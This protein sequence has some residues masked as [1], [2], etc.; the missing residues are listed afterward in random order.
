MKNLKEFNL[1]RLK[2]IF[3]NR[4]DIFINILLIG[5]TLFATISLYSYYSHKKSRLEGQVQDMEGRLALVEDYQKTEKEYQGLVKA[6]PQGI[7]SDQLITKLSDFAV[8]HNVQILTFSPAE[9]KSEEFFEQVSINMNIACDNYDNIVAFLKDIESSSYSIFIQKWSGKI[10]EKAAEKRK[11][12]S[13]ES[14]PSL[15]QRQNP[16]VEA[17]IE[18]TSI[19]LKS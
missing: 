3:T 1:S 7:E 2:E 15:E 6:F 8:A 12:R 16:V 14:A 10:R 9:K 13:L 18:I 5:L 17:N 4:P 19:H 11:G